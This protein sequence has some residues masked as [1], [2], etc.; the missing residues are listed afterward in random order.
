MRFEPKGPED[1]EA[2]EQE[3]DFVNHVVMEQNPGVLIFNTFFKDALLSKTGLVKVSWEKRDIEEEETY[4]DMDDMQFS[5]FASDP[6]LEIIA[7]TVKD[8]PSA[9][10][11]NSDPSTNPSYA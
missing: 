5:I 8:A 4:Y 6:D 11:P 2:A 10:D 7:H 9:S 3:T 1:V